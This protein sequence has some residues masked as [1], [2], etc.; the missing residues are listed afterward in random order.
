MAY[1][2]PWSRTGRGHTLR[3]V[4]KPAILAVDD[5]PSVSQAV[6]RDL[7]AQYGATHR[8]VRAD[9]GDAALRLLADLTLRDR[10]VALVVSDERMPGMTGIELLAKV[11]QQSPET[12]LL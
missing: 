6:A 8:I 1:Q 12:K 4:S 11:R 10:S 3:G 5:D 2:E 9:S 7:R